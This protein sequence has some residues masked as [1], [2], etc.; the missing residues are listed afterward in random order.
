MPN[1]AFIKSSDV[2]AL[3]EN[4][5]LVNRTRQ[6]PNSYEWIIRTAPRSSWIALINSI[7]TPDHYLMRNLSGRLL[8]IAFELYADDLALSYRL[9]HRG[10]TVAAFESHLDLQIAQRLR[11]VVN[12]GD[13]RRLDLAEPID[14][15]VLRHYHDHHRSQP[16]AQ[17][18]APRSVPT[19]LQQHYAGQASDLNELLKS[20]SKSDYLD[21]VLQP[22]YAVE[23]M[24]ERFSSLLDLP[25]L[26]GDTVE[27]PYTADDLSASIM[28]NDDMMM[29]HTIKG[30]DI[31]APTTWPPDAHL[32]EG[33]SRI[34]YQRWI[35]K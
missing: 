14:R 18:T 26:P 13:V 15:L 20:G 33:W 21:D 17:A 34:S 23:T 27:V 2:A 1:L 5:I 28:A 35:S 7:G 6:H 8:A 29:Q 4:I 19:Q 16:W 10:Q 25:Y 32:P 31:L 24:L 11:L 3:D 12:T 9:H 30:Y 22:G